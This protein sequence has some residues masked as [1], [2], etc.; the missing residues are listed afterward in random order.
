MMAML[1]TYIFFNIYII[2]FLHQHA[3]DGGNGQFKS[4]RFLKPTYSVSSRRHRAGLPARSLES[5]TCAESL[6]AM[7]PV[8][9]PRNGG[10]AEAQSQ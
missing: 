2:F 7:N 10:K 5:C 9:Q 6:S 8:D 1:F 3:V 4:S